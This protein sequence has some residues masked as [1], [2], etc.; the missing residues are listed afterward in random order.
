[1]VRQ[2]AEVRVRYEETDPMG[3]VYHANFFRYFE[4]G[5]VELLRARG[6]PYRELEA[7]GVSFAVVEARASYRSPARF[8]DLLTVGCEVTRLRPTR[9]AL[10]YDVTRKD[11]AGKGGR[12]L[13]TGETVLACLDA[14]G[15]PCRL[16]EPV[17]AALTGEVVFGGGGS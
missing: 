16:P 7:R 1:L 8:D 14:E 12:A 11:A 3:V 15:R 5:R 4:V 2:E 9:I 13:V 6:C 10:R 17:R